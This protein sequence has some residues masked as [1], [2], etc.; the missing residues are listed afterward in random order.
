MNPR[1][2]ASSECEAVHAVIAEL[3][4]A[5]SSKDLDRLLALYAP[6]AVAF[7][8]KPPLQ[9]K[10]AA[11]WRAQWAECMPYLP[12]GFTVE[13]RDLT[14]MV[15]HDLALAHWLWHFV[16]MPL[17]HPASQTWMRATSGYRKVGG[18]WKIVHEHHSVPFDPMT[19]QA[20]FTLQP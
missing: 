14:V 12:D 19:S 3:F 4:R 16:G 5:I 17:E 7:D 18:L 2:G 11:N 1:S 13:T 6:E 15:S 20:V 9:I 8:V 10:G